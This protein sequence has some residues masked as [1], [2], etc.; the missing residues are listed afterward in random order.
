MR[1]ET[2]RSELGQLREG[3][4]VA[5]RLF[6]S[7]VP[8]PPT[9]GLA[10]GSKAGG[11]HTELVASVSPAHVDAATCVTTSALV[12]CAWEQTPIPIMPPLTWF[13]LLP[14]PYASAITAE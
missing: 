10:F 6:V 2:S 14:S 1:L 5:V 13:Q 4:W 9:E 8:V 11:A 12:N 7:T 3:C